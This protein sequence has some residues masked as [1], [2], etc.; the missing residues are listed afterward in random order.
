ME[1][2]H[3]QQIK[4]KLKHLETPSSQ[5]VAGICLV[6]DSSNHY[7]LT[8]SEI[9][10][11]ASASPDNLKYIM[12]LADFPDYISKRCNLD[13][14]ITIEIKSQY[15]Q[16]FEEI[17]VLE[18]RILDFFESYKKT[19]QEE[20]ELISRDYSKS[21]QYLNKFNVK[22]VDPSDDIYQSTL[23]IISE[24]VAK[25]KVET[26][27][28]NQSLN[29]AIEKASID[30]LKQRFVG[31]LQ[32][33][34]QTFEEN[35][36]TYPKDILEVG[37]IVVS[38]GKWIPETNGVDIHPSDND[39]ASMGC[40]GDLVIGKLNLNLISHRVKLTNS[41]GSPQNCLWSPLGNM[42]MVSTTVDPSI[43][44]FEADG[45][46]VKSFL[47]TH[48][49]SGWG[50]IWLSETDIAC[51]YEDGVFKTFSLLS[52]Q[53]SWEFKLNGECAW[54]MDVLSNSQ[55]LVGVD[56]SIYNLNWKTK[57]LIW[58]KSEWHSGLCYCL[59]LNKSKDLLI[60]GS[61]DFVI[62]L[63]RIK[64]QTKIWEHKINSYVQG[65][66]WVPGELYIFALGNINQLIALDSRTGT[67][68]FEYNKLPSCCYS[69]RLDQR[70]KQILIGDNKG[71]IR[72]LKLILEAKK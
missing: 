68:I 62:R 6:N 37:E 44:I 45:K 15:D 69:L 48:S 56:S 24:I 63:M 28:F 41:S 30:N 17:N 55:V 70:S 25:T 67:K 54:G 51:G 46:L 61:E 72:K 39:F 42:I 35:S 4:L 52:N 1:S 65:L 33:I 43:Y 22:N 12:P 60:T 31:K 13:E 7:L 21:R 59:K 9:I 40:G 18:T 11:F 3:L 8:S 32:Q 66:T 16:V 27:D 26:L 49:S 29:E 14:Q 58:T 71:V 20:L 53:Q 57:N 47:N 23:Q 38:E 2:D 64:D 50:S 36:Y 34:L 5:M 10:K 19:L